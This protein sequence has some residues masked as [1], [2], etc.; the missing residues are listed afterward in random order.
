MQ[1]EDEPTTARAFDPAAENRASSDPV[2]AATADD[3][4]GRVIR[5]P[6]HPQLEGLEERWA[7]R[8]DAWG[9]YRFDDSKA[10]AEVY[11]I[12]TPPPTV[13][14]AL[15]VGHIFSFTQTDF[16]ARFQR[17]RGKKPYVMTNLKT[18]SGLTQVVEF[19]ETKGM[20]KA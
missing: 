10:R 15:H 2:P 6:D 4:S 16:V 19:I 18:L 17:M 1:A 20:L 9:T 11:S 13:S 14:G 5:I 7:A 12:D 8:W 3:Q